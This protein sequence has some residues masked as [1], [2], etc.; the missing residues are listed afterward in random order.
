TKE[1]PPAPPPAAAPTNGHNNGAQTQGQAPP[2]RP[3]TV[4]PGTLQA[5]AP[6]ITQGHAQQA[7]HAQHAQHPPAQAR[8]RPKAPARPAYSEESQSSVS[9]TS[10]AMPYRR[11][12]KKGGSPTMTIGILIIALAGG[13]GFAAW[14]HARSVAKGRA[15]RALRDAQAELKHDS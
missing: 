14:K 8:P 13:G 12:G 15:A 5:P 2:T 11:G 3:Q 4:P 9:E 1:A 6:Q 10:G 7:Q